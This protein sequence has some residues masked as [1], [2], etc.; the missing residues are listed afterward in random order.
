MKFLILTHTQLTWLFFSPFHSRI[1]ITL[2]I[3]DPSRFHDRL[4][5]IWGTD[6]ESMK[7]QTRFHISQKLATNPM[8]HALDLESGIEG[9]KQG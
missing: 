9:R 8:H 2:G 7:M 6:Q 5:T 4:G 3:D 1:D